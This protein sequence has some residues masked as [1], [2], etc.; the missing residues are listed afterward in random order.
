MAF[1]LILSTV[2]A[3]DSRVKE[4]EAINTIGYGTIFTAASS[5]VAY[6]VFHSFTNLE[7]KECKILGATFGILFNSIMAY[8]MEQNTLSH[9]Y[10]YSTN[11]IAGKLT[12]GVI[13]VNVI[14]L[15]GK[16]NN[17]RFF[18]KKYSSDE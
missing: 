12:G 14:W 6:E 4:N 7:P 10:S 9:G 17:K 2:S 1:L 13:G 16:N 5:L 8:V 15:I 11:H 18:N 3:Q